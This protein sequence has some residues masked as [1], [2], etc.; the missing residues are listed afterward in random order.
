ME[1]KS[2]QDLLQIPSRESAAAE[3]KSAPSSPSKSAVPPP[4]A[5]DSATS[6]GI[7]RLEQAHDAQSAL[8]SVDAAV[9]K[10]GGVMDKV[11]KDKGLSH[12]KSS[13]VHDQINK[14]AEIDKDEEDSDWGLQIIVE[15]GNNWV[16]RLIGASNTDVD[17]PLVKLFE[18]MVAAMCLLVAS[19][20]EDQ[21]PLE[22]R[23]ETLW[24][25]TNDGSFWGVTIRPPSPPD[26]MPQATSA[27]IALLTRLLQI[28]SAVAAKIVQLSTST[29]WNLCKADLL[30][31]KRTLELGIAQSLIEIPHCG[32]FPPSVRA[33]AAM[34][35]AVLAEQDENLPH[36][37]TGLE[38]VAETAIFTINTR[39]PLLEHRGAVVLGRLA[40]HAPY[41]GPAEQL[42][43]NK[44]MISQLGGIGA[45]LDMVRHTQA[46]VF[47]LESKCV[48]DRLPSSRSDA[49]PTCAH[50][51]STAFFFPQ[52][53]LKGGGQNAHPRGR[54]RPRQQG[55]WLRP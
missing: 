16:D 47:H 8:D 25:R 54:C 27:A 17:A 22:G 38:A 7:E 6:A 40:F 43:T 14:R 51:S 23:D 20:H 26:D 24:E 42:Q 4:E 37:P 11:D 13:L 9:N 28:R 2:S 41:G 19:A 45:L 33:I 49:V 21:D 46:R 48:R 32:F 36:I 44:E 12:T 18:F 10:I 53:A 31:Q 3:E 29:L 50:P 30:S 39:L 52:G 34:F 55:F 5:E 15:V 35:L 1:V